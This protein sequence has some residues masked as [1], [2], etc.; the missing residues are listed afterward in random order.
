MRGIT[1]IWILL[2][3]PAVHAFS[4]DHFSTSKNHYL[5]CAPPDSIKTTPSKDTTKS[6]TSYHYIKHRKYV[7]GLDAASDQSNHGLHNSSTKLPYLEPS[8]TYYTKKGFYIETSDQF[9]IVKKNGGFDVLGINPGWNIDLTDNTTLN[10]NYQYYFK[11]KTPNAVSSSLGNDL[12]TYIEQDIGDLTGKLSIDYDIYRQKN[13]KQP[14]TPNDI[15][16]TPDVQYDFEVDFGKKS[17]LIVT[18]EANIAFGTRN[19]Y[20]QYLDNAATD[21]SANNLTPKKAQY[22]AN[23]NSSFGTLD[24]EFVLTIEYKVGKFAFEP[25][26]TYSHPL[27]DP[28][29]VPSTPFFYGSLSFTYTIKSKK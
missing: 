4:A 1:R 26:I 6:D 12:E 7:I 8:F 28:S 29:D 21:S 2:L 19:F 23:S 16:F 17:S 25:S 5:N 13:K 15:I 20:T 22:A 27:Y 3:L 24:Y 18:P 14:K 9:L 11:Q 10:F